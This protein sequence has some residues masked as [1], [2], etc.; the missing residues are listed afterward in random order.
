M[1]Y[2]DNN[3]QNIVQS[4]NNWVLIEL[5]LSYQVVDSAIWLGI[6][7]IIN[8]F[9]KKKLKLHPIPYFSSQGSV[10]DLPT[11]YLWSPALVPKPDGMLQPQTLDILQLFSLRF[12]E[13]IG[14]ARP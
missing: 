14:P 2:L 9:R 12:Y 6:R 1:L 13:K 10:T 7:S 5:Q 3:I 8:D 11:G 4:D